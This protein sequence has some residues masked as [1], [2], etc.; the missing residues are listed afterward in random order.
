MS[1]LAFLEV[2]MLQTKI[3][4][5][6]SGMVQE[7]SSLNDPTKNAE[8]RLAHYN[9]SYLQF[10]Q[11]GMVPTL[12]KIFQLNG[13]SPAI[14]QYA[15]CLLRNIVQFEEGQTA[16]VLESL[17]FDLIGAIKDHCHNSSLTFELVMC[18][19]GCMRSSVINDC[20]K[21]VPLLMNLLRVHS[22][23]PSLV[24]ATVG[25]LFHFAKFGR[26][27]EEMPLF[28]ELLK[29]YSANL[30]VL[31]ELLDLFE[32]LSCLDLGKVQCLVMGLYVYLEELL[33]RHLACPGV[34]ATI[35]AVV[36]NGS[37]NFE[38]GKQVLVKRTKLR[39]LIIKCLKVHCTQEQM[40]LHA[41]AALNTLTFNRPEVQEH[42]I[43]SGIV[44][45][46]VRVFLLHPKCSFLKLH[47]VTLLNKLGYGW[48]GTK[49]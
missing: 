43:H 38:A 1:D 8:E 24:G 30:V 14:L 3:L 44:P 48:D 28:F 26:L 13:G 32:Y 49:K 4:E 11:S 46:L 47:T 36:R 37:C 2:D 20:V 23:V 34:C 17:H 33:E 16:C 40:C 45:I 10:I 29:Q 22:T 7:A 9:K 39:H 19:R 41:M 42:L 12:K 35:L 31:K 15:A 25:T 21:A 18:L 6:L 27:T 5:S